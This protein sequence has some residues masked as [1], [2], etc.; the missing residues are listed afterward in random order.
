M[1]APPAAAV[2]INRPDPHHDRPA[3]ST[4]TPTRT[5]RLLTLVR[6]LIDYGR[7]HATK[8]QQR[9]PTTD[10]AAITRPFGPIDI[11]QILARITSGLLR[12]AAL[13][14][15]LA[16]RLDREQATPATLSTSSPRQPRATPPED[17]SASPADA[18]LARLPT[19]G[20][21]AAE[22]R[23]R[24][25][26]AVIADICCDLGIVPSNPLWR[27]LSRAIIA[28]G[29]SLAAL[30]NDTFKRLSTWLLNP[31]ATAHPAEPAPYRPSTLAPG[32][33]PP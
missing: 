16:R 32:T 2:Q 17:R 29:G 28:N 9:T 11:A 24:P 21:I 20:D 22:V 15:R 23:R 12:A 30:F 31:P 1:S 7:Q 19:P 33:G 10:L 13:E 18:R 4:D 6:A 14:A 25:I 5:S 27:E 8:L 26:G 3:P